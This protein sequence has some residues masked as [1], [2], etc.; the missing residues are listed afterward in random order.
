[1]ENMKKAY[2]LNLAAKNAASPY[3]FLA[4]AD[5]LYPKILWFYLFENMPNKKEVYHFF[6][7]RINKSITEKIFAGVIS[8][9]DIYEKYEG[10][11]ILSSPSFSQ[12]LIIK[13][14]NYLC[15]LVGLKSSFYIDQPIYEE[16][17]GNINPCVYSKDFFM[18]LGGYD[19]N[20]VGWGEDDDLERRTIEA[21]GKNI[22]IP[23]LVGHLWHPRIMDFK[24]YLSGS[25]VYGSKK[26]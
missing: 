7:S 6:L 18:E 10:M 21:G 19:E 26:T 22:R 14:S 5:F 23:V 9:E 25:T 17:F 24:N 4:D 16:I 2:C 8:W 15:S 12:K 1:M 11:H 13:F 3:L 20:F